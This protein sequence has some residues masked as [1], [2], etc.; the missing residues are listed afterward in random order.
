MALLTRS[1]R[2]V[3]GGDGPGDDFEKTDS[4]LATGTGCG[5]GAERESVG[6]EIRNLPPCSRRPRRFT[7]TASAPMWAL[8]RGIKTSSI[9]G[10]EFAEAGPQEGPLPHPFPHGPPGCAQHLHQDLTNQRID[11]PAGIVLHF[12]PQGAP[13]GSGTSGESPIGHGFYLES[14]TETDNKTDPNLGVLRRPPPKT[15]RVRKLPANPRLLGTAFQILPSGRRGI[16]T[17]GRFPATAFPW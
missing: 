11:D 10:V 15:R 2:I 16:D 7:A 14:G 9:Q 17:P 1:I 8:P 6:D 4:L 3:S 13:L 12:S 5:A